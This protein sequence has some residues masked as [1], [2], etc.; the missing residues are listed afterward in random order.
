MWW[1]AIIV[2]VVLALL[3]WVATMGVLSAVARRPANLGAKGGRL[4]PCPDAPNCVSSQADDAAHRMEPIPFDGNADAALARLK[5]VLT[6]RPRT[7]IVE[8]D[9]DYAHAECT[10]LLFRFVDDVECVVD[11]EKG[12]INFRSASR[13]GH[14][15]LGVNRQRMEEVRK[16]FQQ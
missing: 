14:S 10:S 6:A 1:K 3:G 9:G 5:A 7:R 8:A 4:A 15:D 11:R 2:I 12:V 16:A 13:V